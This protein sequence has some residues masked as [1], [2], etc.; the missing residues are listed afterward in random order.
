M[1]FIS[2][3]NLRKYRLLYI[4]CVVVLLAILSPGF[5]VNKVTISQVR[6][7]KSPIKQVFKAVIDPR[8]MK[9]WIPQLENFKVIDGTVDK[10]GKNYL[11]TLKSGKK[12]KVVHERLLKLVWYE[13]ITL[14]L[15][16]NHYTFTVNLKFSETSSGTNLR[17]TVEIEPSNFFWGAFAPYMKHSINKQVTNYLDNLDVYLL[18]EQS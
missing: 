8:K 16:P 10:P 1:S 13:E 5:F 15:F 14:V 2:L 11:I 4:L 6:S 18:Q 3:L 7:F 17:A 12:L 9:R